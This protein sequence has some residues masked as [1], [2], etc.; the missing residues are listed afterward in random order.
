MRFAP[1]LLA[2]LDEPVRRYFAHAIRDGAPIDQP[3]HLAMTGC[4]AGAWL[5]FSATQDNDRDSFT[6]NARVGIGRLSSYGYPP[7]ASGVQGRSSVY[8]H[9]ETRLPREP[10]RGHNRR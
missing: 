4:K 9:R 5:P 7:A 3:M 8:A 1:A 10:E 2:G 6:W